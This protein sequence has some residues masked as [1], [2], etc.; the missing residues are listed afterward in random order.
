[1]CV[2]TKVYALLKSMWSSSELGLVVGE[3][4]AWMNQLSDHVKGKVQEHFKEANSV[5]AS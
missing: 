5:S 3:K 1:M 2:Y 4:E